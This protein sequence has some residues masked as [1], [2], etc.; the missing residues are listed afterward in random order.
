MVSGRTWGADFQSRITWIEWRANDLKV[1]PVAEAAADEGGGRSDAGAQKKIH[2][3][4]GAV[5]QMGRHRAGFYQRPEAGRSKN[6]L[7]W[8]IWRPAG[9]RRDELGQQGST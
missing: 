4:L 1:F 6:C 2:D 8:K 9:Q 3:L 7:T 5:V